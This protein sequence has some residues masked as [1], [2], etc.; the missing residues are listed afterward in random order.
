M[1]KIKKL[2]K[3]F[4]GIKAVDGCSFEIKEKTITALIGP[5]GSG[6]TTIFNLISG[7]LKSDSGKIMFNN[8]DITDKSIEDISNL[9]ISRLFQQSRLF[10][11]LTV[12]ENLLLA[13]D[14][15]DT[16]FWSAFV[17]QYCG[18]SADKRN[19][20]DE[21]IKDILEFIE[22]EKFQNVLAKDLSYGQKRL[23]ELS[24]AILNPHNFLMLDEPVSGVAP[25]LREKIKEILIGLKEKGETI[26]LI[27]H[28]MN[29]AFKVSNDVIVL[30]KGRVIAQGKP[31]EIKNN[32]RVLEAYLG[33]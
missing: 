32:P 4:G 3:S 10:N 26:L 21:K 2:N 29:F 9:G 8:K 13:I 19:K 30:E 12:R 14:N 23:I 6:K 5:N 20:F 31:D 11:N 16:K 7:I 1:L 18:T 27:E 28:N 17:P 24:R 22:M 33:E 15:E 25:R